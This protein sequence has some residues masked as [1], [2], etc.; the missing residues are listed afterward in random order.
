MV[1][2]MK[3]Y[4]MRHGQ[5]GLYA[6]SDEARELTE[7]GRDDSAKMAAWLAKFEPQLDC[8][9]FSPYVRATQTWHVVRN[10]FELGNVEVCNDITPYGDAQDVADYVT[11]LVEQHQYEHVLLVSHLPV[12]SYLTAAL[13]TDN[14][15]PSFATS[16]IACIEVSQS[17]SKL[18]WIQSPASI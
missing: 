1:L 13:T 12:V 7:V 2:V 6:E 5:A 15:L 11:A 4:I 14:S 17:E 8:V 9:L 10:F 16:A 3:I 18:T